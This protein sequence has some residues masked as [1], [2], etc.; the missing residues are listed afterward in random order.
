MT[1]TEFI[2]ELSRN[3]GASITKTGEIVE[4]YHR[5]IM[6]KVV[7]GEDVVFTGF[8][9]FEQGQVAERSGHNPQTREPLVIAAHK[10]PKFT[11]GKVFKDAVKDAVSK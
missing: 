6:E 10:R 1:K 5:L 2:R 8:G 4:A 3:I 7:E 11:A 9:K